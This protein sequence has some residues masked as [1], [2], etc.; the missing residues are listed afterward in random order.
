MGPE[1]A[2]AK[3]RSAGER[4]RV[5]ASRGVAHGA[6]LGHRARGLLGNHRLH[7]FGSD[8]RWPS[9][10]RAAA[11]TLPVYFLFASTRYRTWPRARRSASPSPRTCWRKMIAIGIV[12]AATRHGF[13][14]T[15]VTLAG[16]LVRAR[17]PA[18]TA[19]RQQS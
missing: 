7:A 18:W 11:L 9:P 8:G 16:I 14:G 17:R 5:G 1:A 19:W 6:R 10:G 3:A 15:F 2:R 13:A 4:R 12:R